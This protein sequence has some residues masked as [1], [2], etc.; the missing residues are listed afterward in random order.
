M[1]AVRGATGL[2]AHEGRKLDATAA[3]GAFSTRRASPPD[4]PLTS[5]LRLSLLLPSPNYLRLT[6]VVTPVT[7]HPSFSP[8]A[9]CRDVKPGNV[10]ID[11]AKRQLKLIDWGLA[12]FYT[13]GKEYPVRVA[14]RFYKGPELLVDIKVRGRRAGGGGAVGRGGGGGGGGKAIQ[15]A[16]PTEHRGG[17]VQRGCGAVSN[18]A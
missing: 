9:S 14:T 1:T 2:P 10:L 3:C 12:D 7:P 16:N 13:P 6:A 18:Y 17:T 15:G 5:Y 8:A 4:R 11:H